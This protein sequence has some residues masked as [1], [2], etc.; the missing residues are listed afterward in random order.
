MRRPL[1]LGR[2]LSLLLVL[3]GLRSLSQAYLNII[4]PI[5]LA[6]LAFGPVDIGIIFTA[7]AIA[8]ALLTGAV[9]LLS[10]RFG[11]KTLLVLMALLMSAGALVFA[12]SSNF[13]VLL[14]AAAVSTLGRGGGAGSGGAWGPY[15]PAEQALIAEKAGLRDRTAAFGAVS[16]VGV[17]AGSLGSLVALVPAALQSSFGLSMIEG[18]RL[19]FLLTVGLGIAM[20]LIVLPVREGAP[21]RPTLAATQPRR[22]RLSPRTRGLIARFALTNTANGF[23]VGFLGPFLI[24]WFHSRYGADAAQIGTLFFLINLA[25]APSYLYAQRL[26]R[27]LGEV[28][29]VVVTRTI[30]LI[31]LFVMAQA[32][33]YFLAGALYLV[34]MVAAT[35]A[36][37]VRQSYLMGVV[38]APER[39]SAAG[40]SG[41][42]SQVAGAVSPTLA[43]Y[44]M[45]SVS[46]NLPLELAALFQGVN[47]ALYGLFF[48]NL[49][50][51]EE[52][53]NAAGAGNEP[54][55][56]A[57]PPVKSPDKP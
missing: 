28:N 14:A 7:S 29:A 10:D 48:H 19:L 57:G 49:R 17:L 40:L 39:A 43:G 9:G 56:E 23:A 35:M 53:E 3:R 33:T 51:L 45:Q 31:L 16:F 27:L 15:Y 20:A 21:S 5:Y 2:D 36:L 12:L 34:R 37:P 41:L 55:R 13:L 54:G 8:S 46:L 26:A 47:T 22:S 30:S 24:Y 32:P 44:L 6:R 52:T 18:D 25:T 42:P 50:P 1:W 11:R 38:E 4:V